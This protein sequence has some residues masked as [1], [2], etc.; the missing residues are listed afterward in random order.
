M[1]LGA[2]DV[3]S[4]G[5]VLEVVAIAPVQLL[6]AT[7]EE[8]AAHAAMVESLDKQV[9]GQSVWTQAGD[10]LKGICFYEIICATSGG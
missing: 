2:S 9:K 4:D 3:G 5:Q 8:L 6:A 7:A 10:K 1:D